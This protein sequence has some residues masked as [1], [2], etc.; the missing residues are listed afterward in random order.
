MHFLHGALLFPFFFLVLV[1]AGGYVAL[2]LFAQALRRPVQQRRAARHGGAATPGLAAAPDVRAVPHRRVRAVG[3]RRQAGRHGAGAARQRDGDA[4]HRRLAVDEGHRRTADPA[5]GRA[6]GR[7]D[8]RRPAAGA[9]QPRAGGL[10]PHRQ[11]AGLADA[12][13]ATRSSARSTS[14]QLASYTAIGEG[15]FASLNAIKTFTAATTPKGSKPPPGRIVL[16]SD[17]EN[18]TGPQRRRRRSTPRGRPTSR[19][20]PS[21][22]APR[23]AR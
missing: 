18:T 9:H 16:L 15:I 17:G 3:R 21:P 1:L 7:Q 8:L 12:R 4:G 23:T 5:Q 13:T 11:R 6:D 14:L 10:R 22:S 2:Q 19:C 20:P